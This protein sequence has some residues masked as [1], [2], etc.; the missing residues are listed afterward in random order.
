MAK[1]Q[2]WQF[3]GTPVNCFQLPSNE[4]SGPSFSI[5][6]EFVLGPNSTLVR[7]SY[8]VRIVASPRDIPLSFIIFSDTWNFLKHRRVPLRNVLVLQ[9]KTI[10]TESRYTPSPLL[11]IKLFDARNFLKH[12]RISLRS[13]SVLCDKNKVDGESSFPLSP[14]PSAMKLSITGSLLK[15]RRL[16]LR[17]V[18][19]LRDPSNL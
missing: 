5:R 10:S 15:H 19:A 8:S 6:S 7:I 4:N 18:S 3:W 1:V 17:N 9:D 12:R 16:S 11:S 14:S 2:I 13:F